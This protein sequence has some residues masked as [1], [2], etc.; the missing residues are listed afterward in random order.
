MAKLS[1]FTRAFAGVV[2]G[3]SWSV[4]A[5]AAADDLASL[6]AELEALKSDYNSRVQ[7]LEQRIKA[8][9]N[10]ANA[11]PAAPAAAPP[12]AGSAAAAVPAFPEAAPPAP[13]PAP[14]GKSSGPRKDRA[15]KDV[16]AEWGSIDRK[17]ILRDRTYRRAGDVSRRRLQRRNQLA[18]SCR[19]PQGLQSN[20]M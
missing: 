7:A 19:N 10:A 14:A 16:G 13:L 18:F 8:L 2:L 6:K 3:L 15:V 17:G 11:A 9:E 12:V 4:A 1:P 20:G 5:P